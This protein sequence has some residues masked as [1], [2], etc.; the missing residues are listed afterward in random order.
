MRNSTTISTKNILD[1]INSTK[2]IWK[3]FLA[4]LA[5]STKLLTA[6]V[7]TSVIWVTTTWCWTV[8]TVN[9][10]YFRLKPWEI[11]I[12]NTTLEPW[13][14][15]IEVSTNNEYW[16]AAMEISV[17]NSYYEIENYYIN[18]WFNWKTETFR[19]TINKTTKIKI[20]V[21]NVWNDNSWFYLRINKENTSKY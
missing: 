7:A 3:N 20:W 5:L 4:S 2:E 18:N 10:D 11:N 15:E 13:T 14:Y 16:D 8:E 17:W 19:L 12:Y 1:T 21:K 6:T 9:K